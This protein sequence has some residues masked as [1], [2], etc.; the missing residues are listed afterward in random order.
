MIMVIA[1]FKQKNLLAIDESLPRF[2]TACGAGT[3]GGEVK[4][5]ACV[6]MVVISHRHF[7][8]QR[9]AGTPGVFPAEERAGDGASGTP[10][11]L[12]SGAG[13]RQGACL[14]G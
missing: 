10:G 5:P 2:F 7:L 14:P 13:A 1:S 11:A 3:R 12:P 4:G 8:V 6:Q 9:M